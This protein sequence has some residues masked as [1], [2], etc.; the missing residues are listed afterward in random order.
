MSR[1]QRENVTSKKLMLQNCAEYFKARLEDGR[2]TFKRKN[3][4]N[5]EA[6]DRES[7]PIAIKRPTSALQKRREKSRTVGT[8]S[9][10]RNQSLGRKQRPQTASSRGRGPVVA[11]TSASDSL[12]MTSAAADSTALTTSLGN[13]RSSVS[14]KEVLTLENLTLDL[15]EF[16]SFMAKFDADGQPPASSSEVQEVFKACG[17]NLGRLFKLM[18]FSKRAEIVKKTK[19]TASGKV[20]KAP[21]MERPI[22][23]DGLFDKKGK[24]E[25]YVK[26]PE[27]DMIPRRF[28]YRFSKTAVQPPSWFE[29]RDITRSAQLPNKTLEL[30]Y[31]FGFKDD[32][33][34][35]SLYMIPDTGELIFYAAAVVVMHDPVNNKQRFFQHHTDDISRICLHPNGQLI[36]SCHIGKSPLICIWDQRT[37]E[38]V[39]II[40][41]VPKEGG[42][43]A[44]NAAGRSDED[45]AEAKKGSTGGRVPFYERAI[46]GINFSDNG[47][48]LIG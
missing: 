15:D 23:Q 43:E 27:K 21:T 10:P 44:E 41:T 29:P 18:Y 39:K 13:Q 37:S 2:I 25:R 42:A 22:L 45:P 14:M 40:G 6:V 12:G 30:E 26:A 35:Q 36:A 31:V 48:Y 34:T 17:G 33:S 16:T 4:E 19:K 9:P 32:D 7:A 47:K 38:V 11:A 5:E 8:T 3:E 28:K 46:S 1:S 24:G 20:V